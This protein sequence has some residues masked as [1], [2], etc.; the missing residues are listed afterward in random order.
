VTILVVKAAS[1]SIHPRRLCWLPAV[2]YRQY[3]K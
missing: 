2:K 1:L 3:C